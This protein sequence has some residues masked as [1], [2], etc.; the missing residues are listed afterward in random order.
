[1]HTSPLQLVLVLEVIL[2]LV[3]VLLEAAEFVKLLA[4]AGYLRV[5]IMNN[6]INNTNATLVN[7]LTL[8]QTKRTN[9]NHTVER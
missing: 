8:S 7:I 3:L 9:N 6:S 4:F 1:M 2:V 5:A